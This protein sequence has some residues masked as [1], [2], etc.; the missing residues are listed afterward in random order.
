[1][2]DHPLVRAVLDRLLR[3]EGTHARIGTWYLQ[4]AADRLTADDR[5]HLAQIALDAIAVYQPLWHED[6]CETCET[7]A[8]LGGMPVASH[9]EVMVDAVRTRIARPLARLGIAIDAERLEALLV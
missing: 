2:T 3:D 1:M 5:A 4:W 9:A 7:P 8:D 6:R